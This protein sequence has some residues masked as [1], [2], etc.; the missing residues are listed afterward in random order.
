MATSHKNGAEAVRRAHLRRRFRAATLLL[1][2]AALTQATAILTI[3]WNIDYRYDDRQHLAEGW[4]GLGASPHDPP[5]RCVSPGK[6]F[7]G[8]DPP[9]AREVDA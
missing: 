9:A 6:A 2:A 4:A 8:H 1:L 5:S 7:L 3:G